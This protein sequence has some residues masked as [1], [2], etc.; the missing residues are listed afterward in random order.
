MDDLGLATLKAG[1]DADCRVAVSAAAL[2]RERLGTGRA[3]ELEACAFQLVRF[4][5]VVEQ[6]GLRIAKAFENHIDD[7]RGWHTGLIRRL[8]L[9]IPGVRPAFFPEPLAPDL[10]ELRG[11]RHVVVHAYE[12]ML[13]REKLLPVLEA[14]ERVAGRLTSLCEAFFK[15]IFAP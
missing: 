5:N 11:F 7:D 15:Q 13:R 8:T 2:A 6:M 9:D 4:Y 10:L 3:P 12:L 1:I 14:A